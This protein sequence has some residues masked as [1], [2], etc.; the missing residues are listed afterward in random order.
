[1]SEPG[2]EMPPKILIVDPN[3][4]FATMLEQMLE[5]EG[6]YVVHRANSGSDALALLHRT[7]FDLAII[8]M[9]LDPEDLSYRDLILNIRKL[10]PAMRCV[11]IPLMG[12][13]LPPEAGQLELQGTLAKPFFVD[14]L[15]PSIEGALAK[16]I[17]VPSRRPMVPP[18]TAPPE[19]QAGSQIQI[20][21]AQ[22]AYELNSD[23]VLLLSTEAEGT[24]IIA[25]V[26][27]LDELRLSRLADHVTHVVRSAQETARFL[28][29]P[30]RSFEHSVFEGE[31]L[32]L[33][34]IAITENL[35]LVVTTPAS[36]PLGMVRHRL[37]RTARTLS[38]FD[39]K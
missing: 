26:S 31:E 16:E 23:I 28:G 5:V 8:D 37:R 18:E 32:R 19:R 13:A 15:L 38:H 3:E 29:Q 14:D 35:V 20:E 17:R 34:I 21:L 2:E 9:D 1:M 7:H 6:N 4:A 22:L 36:T 33:Y 30:H 24:Q 39:D 10:K 11:V 12:Q 27:T 25:Q